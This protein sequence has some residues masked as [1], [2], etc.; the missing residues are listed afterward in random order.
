MKSEVYSWRLSSDTK[1]ALEMEARREN[2]TVSALLDRL[3]QEWIEKRRA[4]SSSDSSEQA[5]L[6]ALAD[7]WIGSIAG[8]NP[9]R[10]ESVRQLVRRR[11]AENHGRKLP[12]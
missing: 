5:R 3:A 9:K 1:A 4:Q 7:K 10:A 6:H 8:K 11:L 2:T 12:R